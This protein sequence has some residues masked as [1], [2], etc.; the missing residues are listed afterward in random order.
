MVVGTF[1][2]QAIETDVDFL[3]GLLSKHN[4]V[5]LEGFM[6][7]HTFASR[8]M[9]YRGKVLDAASTKRLQRSTCISRSSLAHADRL[10]GALCNS[11]RDVNRSLTRTFRGSAGCLFVV[12][13]S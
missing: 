7:H 8:H 2:G 5:R 3:H 11:G 1:M 13:G 4:F 10:S 12:G 6:Y 9:V